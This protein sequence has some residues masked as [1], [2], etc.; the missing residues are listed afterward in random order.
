[1]NIAQYEI[2][3][4]VDHSQYYQGAGTMHT[5]Y[6]QVFVGV[7]DTEREAIEDA[8]EL[9]AQSD[10]VLDSD[11]EH[12]LDRD[13]YLAEESSVY[14]YYLEQETPDYEET[15]TIHHRAHCGLTHEPIVCDSEREARDIL[16]NKLKLYRLYSKVTQIDR[17]TYEIET[18]TDY[19]I[20][21]TDGVFYVLRTD[22]QEEI[23]NFE[24]TFAEGFEIHMYAE[25]YIKGA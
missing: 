19:M 13:I 18:D 15:Y 25:L 10:F 11:T 8:I 17:Y 6:D 2:L 21:D 14:E 16:A 1:M 5:D 24:E 22:N 12:E 3:T 4:S 9:L 23:D 20:P 7:G